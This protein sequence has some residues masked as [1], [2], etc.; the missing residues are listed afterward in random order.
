MVMKSMRQVTKPVVWIV[1]LAF[2]G[3]IFLAWGMDLTRRP[4]ER[5]VV[6]KVAGRQIQNEEYRQVLNYVYNQR[7]QENPNQDLPASQ[8]NR[9]RDEAFTT[10]VNDILFAR[11]RDRLSLEVPDNELVDHLRR[12]PPDF[13]QQNPSFAD[14]SGNFDYSKYQQAMLDPQLGEFWTQVESAVRP[15]LQQLKLQEYVVSLTHVTDPEVKMYFRASNA[16]RQVRYVTVDATEYLSTIPTPDSGAVREYYRA[17][18]EKFRRDEHVDLEYVTFIKR[19]SSEDTALVLN[20]M[21][22]IRRRLEEGAEFNELARTYSE[23]PG[24]TESGGDL[25]WF[26]QGRMVPAFDSA[27][28]ALEP[29]EV[30]DPILTRF[31]YHLIKLHDKR[32]QND[33]TQVHAS[34]ILLKLETSGRTTSDL[35]LRAEQ[36]A[37]DAATM[38][39]DSVCALYGVDPRSATNV[40]RGSNIG[41]FGPNR[42]LEEFLFNADEG[43]ISSVISTDRFF[44]VCRLTNHESAGT[45]PIDE[46]W[47]RV[48]RALKMDM[49]AD[50]ALAAVKLVQAE[51]EAG[52]SLEEAAEVIGRQ[53]QVT[54]EFGRYDVV[55]PF[56]TEPVFHGVA[57]SLTEEEPISPPF[58]SGTK[59]CIIELVETNPADMEMYAE[60]RDSLYQAILGG[61]QNQVY[62]IWYDELYSNAEV[63]DFRY[64]LPE[65]Y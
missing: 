50:S 22:D 65:D 54:K 7:A 59:Y 13:L 46:V 2:V 61:K 14:E 40:E 16:Q 9:I 43:E 15:Q 31:G 34:H 32:Q 26:G 6:G 17:H 23:E 27:V 41:A 39:W 24:A 47:G 60:K 35:Q 48:V 18:P 51:I 53:A 58:L 33:S 29:G 52:G 44:G 1:A 64:Q 5:G 56:G 12:F 4:G 38:P 25:G 36:F 10:L 19:P 3:T 21:N 45:D 42:A 37:S 63:K 28:F 11:E 62:Q 57:F 30:S 55:Q 49:G 8:M 20:E